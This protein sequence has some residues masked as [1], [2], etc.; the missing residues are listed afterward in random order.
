[1][2]DLCGLVRL[3]SRVH[4]SV[5]AATRLDCLS[6]GLCLIRDFFHSDVV[7]LHTV[8]NRAAVL[9]RNEAARTVKV[10]RTC[11]KARRGSKLGHTKYQRMQG[12]ARRFRFVCFRHCACCRM[13]SVRSRM[14]VSGSYNLQSLYL[15]SPFLG[16]RVGPIASRLQSCAGIS[17][18][19]PE[20]HILSYL[21]KTPRRWGSAPSGG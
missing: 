19:H 10:S 2:P 3:R 17:A 20:S 13:K 12:L 21:F 5:P 11:V 15:P 6:G 16:H 1:M 14:R 9:C 4:E 8:R 7:E 18:I